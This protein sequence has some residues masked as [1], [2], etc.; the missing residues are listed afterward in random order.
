MATIGSFKKVGNDYQGEI[1]TRIMGEARDE[2]VRT[3]VDW[4]L[5][6]REGTAPEPLIKRY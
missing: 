5:K 6:K 3:A 2:D 1:V 4:L